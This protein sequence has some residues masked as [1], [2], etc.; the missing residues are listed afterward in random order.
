MAVKIFHKDHGFVITS[1]QEMIDMLLAK[2]GIITTKA[3]AIP[4]PVPAQ[5]EIVNQSRTKRKGE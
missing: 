5:K 3:N 1:D 2:G 4:D